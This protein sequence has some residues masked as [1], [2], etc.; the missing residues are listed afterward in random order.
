MGRLMKN[1]ILPNQDF[2][3]LNICVDSIEEKLTK[4]IKKDATSSTRLL[5]IMYTN[6]CG[7]FVVNSF[8]K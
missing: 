3:D 8:E 2:I 5:Q 6:I 4:H 7:S 1:E